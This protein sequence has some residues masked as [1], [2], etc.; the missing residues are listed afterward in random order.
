MIVFLKTSE[1]ATCEPLSKCKYTW[2]S[3]LPNVTAFNLTFDESS[4][5]WQLKAS[6]NDFTGDTSS[7]ELYIANMKQTTTSVSTTEAV[8]IINNV[9]SQ[10]LN[11]QKLYFDVGI[12][13]GHSIVEASYELTPKL[14]SISPNSGSVGGTV[15]TAQVPGA[16]VSS[17]VSIV[18][19]T[20]ASICQSVS[21]TS[22]G[23]VEGKALAQE[24]TSTQL[25]IKQGTTVY[26]CV[27]SDNSNCQYEQLASSTFPAV[28]SVSKTDTTIVFAG[29]NFDIADFS[30]SASFAGITAD[31]VVVDSA[32]Q[33][34]ATFTLGVP[35]VSTDQYPELVF[36]KSALIYHAPSAA[37]LANALSVSSSLSGLQ[38]SFAGEC[39]YEVTSTGL[40][41]IVK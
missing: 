12:P 40:A 14:V 38:C 29:T 41:S 13:H 35:V 11:A 4:Y 18:D 8:F 25:S 19:S 10:T 3:F 17:T 33:A 36:N 30:A 28:T 32:T 9:T 23:V 1:E 34:T 22:Y 39:T 20:G 7:T 6:G 16:T 26:P 27:N 2:N 5:Q 24:I 21:V 37:V 15:I 31:S